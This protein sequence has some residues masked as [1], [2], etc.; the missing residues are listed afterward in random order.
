[1]ACRTT[2]RASLFDNSL[3]WGVDGAY[4]EIDVI[5]RA[6]VHRRKFL[7]PPFGVTLQSRLCLARGPSHV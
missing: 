6:L 4:I 2:T 1:M 3:E 5:D 7:Q